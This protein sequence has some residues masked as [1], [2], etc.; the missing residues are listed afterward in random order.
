MRRFCRYLVIFIFLS[1]WLSIAS[2]QVVNMP[3]PNLRA[4]VRDALGLAPN[5]PIT[6]QAMRGLTFLNAQSS[7]IEEITGQ[8]GR[9]R[10]LTGLEHG[11]QLTKLWLSNNQISDIRPLAGLTQLQDLHI[12]NNQI[13]DITPLTRLPQLES[14]AIADNPI[15]N[16]RPLAGLTQLRDLN[17]SVGRISDIRPHVDLTQLDSLGIWGDWESRSPISDLDLL[18]NLTQLT[19]LEVNAAS[20]S[21]L[22]FL[23]GLTQLTWLDLSDNQISDLKPLAGLTQLKWLHLRGNQISDLKPLAGLTQLEGLYLSFN[24]ISDLKPLAGL[25][26]LTDLGLEYNQIRDVSPLAGLTN[27]NYLHLRNNPIRDASSL[28]NLSNLRYVD[29]PIPPAI[30][31]RNEIPD[32]LPKVGKTLEYRVLI[33]NAKNVTGFNLTYQ[34]PHKL[35]SVKSVGW[36]DGVEH[37]PRNTLRTGILTASRLETGQDIRNVAIFTLNATAAGESEL[38]V[39]GHLTTTQGRVN[40]DIRYPITIFPSDEPQPSDNAVVIPDANLR[41]AV[42]KAL[43]LGQNGRITKQKMRGLTELKAP[44]SQIRDLT[45]LEHATE[46]TRLDIQEN[47]ISDLRPLIDL[48]KLWR[49]E[50][51]ENQ[52]RDIRP[53]AGL[54]KLTGL[55]LSRNQIQDLTPIAGLTELRGLSL[56]YNIPKIRGITSLSDLTKLEWLHLVGNQISDVSP[57]AGLANL[58]TLWLKG[59]PIQDASPLASLTKLKNVDVEIPKQG[60]PSTGTWLF[61]HKPSNLTPDNF[62]IGPGEFAILVHQGKQNA[63]KKADFKTYASYYAHDDNTDFPNL[64]QFFRNRGRIELISN[65]GHNPLPPDTKAPQFGDIVISEIM[66]GLNGASPAN[67]YIELYNASAHTY[68]FWEGNLSLRFSKASESPLPAGVFPFP[69]NPNAHTKV[70]DRM[71]NKGWKVPGSS[72]SHGKQIP[73]VS[74]YRV[75]NYKTGAVPDGTVARSWKASKGRVNLPAPSLGTPGAKHVSDGEVPVVHVKSP[76]RPPMYWVDMEKGTLHRLIGDE[77]EDPVP[78]TSQVTSLTV[79][80]ASGK[81]YWTMKIN[82]Q[83]N[84]RRGR[85]RLAN[86]NGTNHRILKDLTHVPPGI[87]LDVESDKIYLTNPSGTIQQLNFDGSNFQSN[88]ITGLNSP[89]DIAVDGERGQLYW[90]ESDSI[91]RADLNG[92]NREAFAPNL[93]ELGSIT[94]AGGKIYSIERP[95]GEQR[96]QIRSSTFDGL[97]PPQTL[98]TLQIR[99]MGLAVD[100][101]DSKLYWTS[102]DGKIQRAD[103]NGENIQDVVTGLKAPGAIVL[104]IPTRTNPAAPGNTSLV[105]RQL[106]EETL[107]LA[108]YPNPFNPETWIP[109]Q[110][111]TDTDVQLLIYNAHGSIVQRLVLGHQRAGT[112][113][114]RSRAAYWDGRN[115]L[116]ERVASGLYFYQLQTDNVSSLRKMLILK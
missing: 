12:W 105:T 60:T 28:A 31:I 86:L 35:T 3:D 108:N 87:A 25:T 49:L 34:T 56:G 14:L 45:G 54:T 2:A 58:E 73:F 63:F 93:G 109:Y 55:F 30:S 81:L 38:R 53:L 13:S 1:S 65:T 91:W 21:D 43:G 102:A 50:I 75:I 116:G 112:Y 40:V 72:R 67:Q 4:V 18:G 88:F 115:T 90:T 92:N 98:V 80:V 26:Q 64:A 6:R 106:P 59:N 9:I 94:I 62:T 36:F 97:T 84:D 100:T 42:R 99:P 114:D 23:R 48:K 66:W 79:D 27:L 71:S 46:L 95:G 37:N 104:G 8:Y 68:T 69:S 44:N 20:V 83:K 70:V 24:Q 41:A 96:W 19:G 17:I 33:R 107:L 22:S 16:F 111:A 39:R 5:A 77:V 57:L 101:A 11:T 47:Q 32:E 78:N 76:S 51:W 103:L 113:I 89:K 82:S 7:R 15:N 110:L 85:I 10:D 61:I 29:I 74:M 52:I